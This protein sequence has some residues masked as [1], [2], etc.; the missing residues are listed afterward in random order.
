MSETHLTDTAFSS[1][2]LPDK[3]MQGIE[4]SGFSMCT[5]IQA[6]TLPVALAGKDVAGQ[7]QT[8]TGKTAAF[9]VAVYNH[10]LTHEADEHRKVNQPRALILAPTR[11]LAI[12]I[13]SDAR[14]I[15]Q[16]TGLKPVLAYGGTG[17]E[18]QRDEI[19]AGVDILIGTPGRL[20]DYFKQHVYNLKMAQV[21]VLDEA[22]RM[23]DLG[24][25]K[26]IRY[27]FRRCP[28]PEQRLGLLFSA[29]L[30]HRV[31]ELA[32]EHM[33]NPVHINVEPEKVTADRVRQVLYHTSNE[34]KIPLLVG[35]LSHGDSRRSI[36][37]V[38][39]KRTAERVWSYLEGNEIKCAVL[40]GDVPQTKRQRLLKEFQEG[41][42]PVLIATDVAARGLHV[43]DVSHVFNYDLPQ[44]A[45][46]YVHRIGRTARV[47]KD[48]DAIS[49]A[50]EN[51]V[52]SLPE[53]EAF[54]GHKIPVEAVSDDCIAEL[55]P[56]VR[57]MRPPPRPG[58]G[59]GG[60]GRGKGTSG[61]QGGNRNRQRQ[62]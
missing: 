31:Q 32:Y 52:Y 42:L 11:E 55:K 53:I 20:I 25:I 28:P 24:F 9:L 16:H 35:L 46:D 22:D 62:R 13:H 48:G 14:V 60:P 10:L 38:N 15:G 5:P 37:F 41:K 3:L 1:F 45:E 33:N 36:V 49:F 26:D 18:Q 7:A 30:S 8:G 6:E 27:L 17:Y 44:D 2:S 59:R 57:I 56:P 34:E 39:T 43:P 4:D 23:F 51:Y 21:I 29:T 47:G 58:G 50:F 12:Q 61:R 19:T 40:S 54:I